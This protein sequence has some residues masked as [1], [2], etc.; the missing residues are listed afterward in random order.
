M[1]DSDSDQDYTIEQADSGASNCH[2]VQCSAL[3]VGGHVVMRNRPCRITDM[4]TSKTG[5]HGHAKC[6]IVGVDIFTGKKYEMISPSTH[7]VMVPTVTR[8]E[9]TLCSID[10]GFCSLMTEDGTTRDDLKVPEG[11]IGEQI[12]EL[13]DEGKELTINVLSAMGESAIVAFKKV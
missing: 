6:V 1:A 4:A 13:F 3:R 2:P 8:T 12:Q 11:E 9:Y 10:D 5:K 7:N